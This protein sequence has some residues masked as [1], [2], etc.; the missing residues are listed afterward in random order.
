MTIAQIEIQTKRFSERRDDLAWLVGGLNDEIEELKKAALPNIK[1]AV[2]KAAE[3]HDK[4]AAM[5]EEGKD[6]FVKPRT[7]I[8][9]G[10]KIGFRKGKGGI[11]FEDEARVMELIEKHF[12]EQTADSLIRV[13]TSLDKKA[14]AT[15][16]VAELKKIGCT[17]EDTGDVV[18]I[19]AVDSEV[20][21]IVRALLKEATTADE[22]KEAA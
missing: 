20:D 9:H 1:R 13:K 11:E 18:V 6:L 10:I 2:A 5:I 8:F 4:L 19:A 16:T 7:M 21:K 14:L 15:L 17:A 22:Q 12:D 3:E